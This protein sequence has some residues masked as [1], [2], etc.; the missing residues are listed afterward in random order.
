MPEAI[1]QSELEKAEMVIKDNI[2]NIKDRKQKGFELTAYKHLSDIYKILSQD[3]EDKDISVYDEKVIEHLIMF[4]S[5]TKINN[6]DAFISDSKKMGNWVDNCD[7]L[8]AL[9]SLTDQVIKVITDSSIDN[10]KELLEKLK[11]KIIKECEDKDQ[12][13]RAERIGK[14]IEEILGEEKDKKYM[15]NFFKK[16]MENI[17]PE[18]SSSG[19]KN[20]TRKDICER[21]DINEMEFD[22]GFFDRSEM[23]E[24]KHIAEVIVLRRWNS[25]S[26]GLYKESTGS[27]GGGYLLRIKKYLFSFSDIAKKNDN[28]RL[29]NLLRTLHYYVLAKNMEGAKYS[30]EKGE[31]RITKDNEK[32]ATLKIKK[33]FCYLERD[34]HD[35][36]KIGVVRKEDN[37]LNIY[38][39]DPHVE[40]I[41]IDPG[42]NFIQNFRDE[43]FHVED[44]DTIIITH[45]HLDHCAEL[46]QIMDL[47]YQFNK[48]YTDTPHEKRQR[49]RV[50]LCLS[51][52]AYTKF[53]SF[54]NE[55]WQKQLK[56][57]IIFE[58]LDD[59]KC[60]PFKGLRISAIPTPHMDLG[61]VNAIGLKI[62]IG[63]EKKKLC[64]GF[65]G[66][67]L[68]SKKIR[69]K[70]KECD[71]LCVHLGSIK[72][73]EIGYRDDRYN[74]RIMKKPREIETK[75]EQLEAFK[76]ENT[77]AN[78]LLFFGTL[79]FIEHCSVKDEPLIIVG[80]FGEELKYGLRTDLCS[81]LRDEANKN[82]KEKK[83]IVCLPGDI[84]LYIGIEE[85]R[86]K[87][88]RC[89][90]CEKFVDQKEIE[91]FSYGREDAIHY[92]CK[93]CDKTL[94]D[95]QKQAV[96]QYRV[97]RH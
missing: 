76:K 33:N 3:K 65:T 46:L 82:K 14:Q 93:T 27:L 62:K 67:T 15:E 19:K 77:T 20:L 53:S 69:G 74:L 54:T 41:V 84:G 47:L 87:K 95:L 63:I 85:D 24:K 52:G 88:V 17:F 48:R 32:I 22:S 35:E 37:K 13:H 75:K 55:S 43:G 8:D 80:E 59:K 45:S 57:V 12:L 79:D 90:F 25:F 36:L 38:S 6:L 49:K 44:I 50:N 60:E 92:I 40:N 97:T 56:D 21:L 4:I 30:E 73:H 5:E 23:K 28:L 83:K 29:L 94:T 39:E 71:L 86:T 1:K 58:N 96:I 78:H 18:E 68:W 51:K 89:N 2:D 11:E 72:Y 81:K 16:K 34:K 91:T 9:E 66:D 42:Y 64:F 70:F 26:P 61:G 31:I 7:D 10:Y